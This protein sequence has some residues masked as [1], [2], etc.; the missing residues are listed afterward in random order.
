MTTIEEA[1]EILW[2][3]AENMSD[4]ELQRF[5]DLIGTVCS[6]MIEK[7]VSNK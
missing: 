2:S 5:I 7:E 1:R 4:D 6:I 3:K